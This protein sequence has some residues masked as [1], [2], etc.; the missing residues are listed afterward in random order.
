[1]KRSVIGVF[2]LT[3][4]LVL[5]SLTRPTPG[6]QES[7]NVGYVDLDRI[8]QEYKD[9]QKALSEIN[10]IRDK[11]QKALDEL[12]GTFDQ[13]VRRYEL[14][15]GLWPSEEEKNKELEDLRRKWNLLNEQKAEKDRELENKSREKLAPLISQIKDAIQVVSKQL[16]KH[17]IFKRR[18]LAY[19][20]SRLDI[21]G[22]VLAFLNKE[23]SK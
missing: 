4:V 9:Y 15:D 14:K 13:R 7:L 19:F 5:V 1:M 18:D 12:A 11:E 22:E 16:G 2:F 3:A 8:R 21:T 20:D 6:A 17:L 10:A 23:E